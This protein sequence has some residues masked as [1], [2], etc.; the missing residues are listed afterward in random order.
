MVRFCQYLAARNYSPFTIEQRTRAIGAFNA[1]AAVRGVERPQD[2]TLPILERYQRHLFHHR[3]VDGEP[4]TFR[5]QIVRLVPLRAFFKWLARER[6]ILFNPAADL[7]L[8]RGE[9][10][11]PATILAPEEV[12]AVM[13]LPDIATPQGLRDRTILEVLYAT[14]ARRLE[15]TRLRVFD[16]DYA[17]KLIVIRKGKGGKDRVVPTGERALSWLAAYRD[18][19]RPHLVAGADDGVLFLSAKGAALNPKK[20]SDRVSRYVSAA[21]LNKTGSCHLFRHTAATLMLENGA[22]IRFI[23][24]MLGHES[25]DTTQIYTQV[26][27]AKLA[28]VHAA[29]HPGAKLKRESVFAALERES[30]EEGDDL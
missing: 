2:V 4:L 28:A 25:L 27:I 22:D 13:A 6:V 12:E 20:L 18:Q 5:T 16:I 24:A 15:I 14:G 21:G 29:T 11:L 30:D 9:K 19:G 7:E 3:K 23:Q 10:R 1:W 26:G 17:R 8:P